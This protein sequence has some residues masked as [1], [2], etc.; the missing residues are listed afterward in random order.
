MVIPKPTYKKRKPVPV[1][2]IHLQDE[3]ECFVCCTT[4]NLERHHCIHGNGNRPK[5]EKYNLVVWLCS[6]CH[7]GTSGVHFNP[8]MDA[9]LKRYA[10]LEFEKVYSRDKWMDVFRRSYL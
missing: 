3:K 4:Q 5:S 7:R 6:E 9:E 1:Q 8:Q 2:K 10:Q